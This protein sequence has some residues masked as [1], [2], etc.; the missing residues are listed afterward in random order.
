M[1]VDATREFCRKHPGIGAVLVRK[2]R[3][4]AAP[5]VLVFGSHPME[6]QLFRIA[7][8]WHFLYE[9]IFKIAS[10][11][12]PDPY[13]TSRYFLQ[14]STGRLRDSLAAGDLRPASAFA[15][16]DKWNDDIVAYFKAQN[17]ALTLEQEPGLAKVRDQLKLHIADT[18]ADDGV[19]HDD[20]PIDWVMVHEEVLKLASEQEGQRFT[21]WPTSSPR[22]V[23]SGPCSVAWCPILKVSTGSPRNPSRPASIGATTRSSSTTTGAAMPSA[24]SSGRS[25]PCSATA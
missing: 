18:L 9:G 8:G 3:D 1:G 12:L 23:L 6:V 14:A 17:N 25:W 20:L 19:S 22:T 16:L 5:E 21:L 2:A 4:H 11:S 10:D 24:P 7:I 15:H 13:R